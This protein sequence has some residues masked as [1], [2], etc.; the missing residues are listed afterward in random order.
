MV[1]KG[2]RVEATN[3]TIIGTG[4]TCPS[5][6]TVPT[7]KTF[8]L[9]DISIIPTYGVDVPVGVAS[10]DVIAFYDVSAGGSTAASGTTNAKFKLNWDLQ[11]TT[12]GGTAVAYSR[13]NGMV[14][15]FTNG[16]EFSNGFTAEL[17][18]ANSLNVGTGCM[19]IAGIYR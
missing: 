19:W 13:G 3:S 6:L 18:G 14:Y 17:S 11:V 5:L 4:G 10:A 16:P 15:H 9:T 2:V 8:I 1:V 7:G 12:G